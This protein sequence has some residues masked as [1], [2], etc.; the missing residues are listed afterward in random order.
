MGPKNATTQQ[1]TGVVNTMSMRNELIAD[2]LMGAAFADNR[3]DGREYAAVKKLLAEVVD[4]EELPADMEARLKAFNPKTF[5]PVGA[6]KSLMLTEDS[7]KRKLIELLAA[8]TE[9]D[10]VLDFDED[11]YIKT[12]AEALEMPKEAYADLSIEILS[13]ENL[14]DAGSKLLEPP[15]PPTDD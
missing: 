2:L 13:V 15:P 5:D 10:D 12:V 3:L 14:Q 11:A 8:V 9:A 6:A 4:A 7:E 1:E